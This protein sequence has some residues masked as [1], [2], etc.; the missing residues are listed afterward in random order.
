MVGMQGVHSVLFGCKASM[1]SAELDLIKPHNKLTN[2]PEILSH[3]Q[4][5]MANILANNYLFTQSSNLSIQLEL[6]FRP[7]DDQSPISTHILA[8][9]WSPP[10][11]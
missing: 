11:S 5:V 7:P 4:V 9:F 3:H 10:T 6:C 2:S 1:S 8:L